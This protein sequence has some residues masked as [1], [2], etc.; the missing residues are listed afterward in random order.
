M[1]D[2][3]RQVVT[4]FKSRIPDEILRL[5]RTVVVFG[6]RARDDAPDDSDLDLMVLVDELTPGMEERLDD[7]AYG[8]MW[9][10]DFK[11]IISLKVF[12]EARYRSA[13]ER[14]FSFYRNV[15]KEGVPV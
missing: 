11:P 12:T 13:L 1:R 10:R 6:S 8:V 5:V 9:D 14:D 2:E 4:E 3:D 15:E 7:I